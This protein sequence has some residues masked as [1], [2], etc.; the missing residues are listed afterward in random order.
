MEG[1]LQCHSFLTLLGHQFA[2]LKVQNLNVYMSGAN[3]VQQNPRKRSQIDIPRYFWKWVKE[4]ETWGRSLTAMK[5]GR[6][7][8]CKQK[9]MWGCGYHTSKKGLRAINM[10]NGDSWPSRPLCFQYFTLYIRVRK[11]L[12]GNQTGPS[13]NNERYQY[14]GSQSTLKWTSKSTSHCP[15]WAHS[16]NPLLLIMSPQS[17]CTRHLA[18]AAKSLQCVW[19]C[20][21][22]RW[23]PTRLPRPWDSPGKNTGVGCHFLLQGMKVKVKPLSH[24]QHFTTPWTAAYQAAPFIGFSRQEYWSGVPLPSPRHLAG[25]L[26]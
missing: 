18:A 9:H 2:S 4:R 7:G 6:F 16:S 14:E 23:K 11:T 22:H 10:L 26:K 8:V 1:T 12:V 17:R 24:V 25:S 15:L 21:T 5:I 20:A 19:L 3:C 13:G